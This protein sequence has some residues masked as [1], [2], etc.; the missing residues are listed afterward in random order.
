MTGLLPYTA[1]RVSI[2]H[3]GKSSKLTQ[4]T[5]SYHYS[6]STANI[7]EVTDYS[8]GFR[9]IGLLGIYVVVIRGCEGREKDEMSVSVGDNVRLLYCDHQWL[10][11]AVR[12]G[13]VGFIP[14]SHCRLTRRHCL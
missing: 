5:H 13:M 6:M 10:Y 3:Y 9:Q 8:D 1:C 7:V 12:D 2:A 4:L 11:G 14:R